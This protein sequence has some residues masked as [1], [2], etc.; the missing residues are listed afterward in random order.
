MLKYKELFAGPKLVLQLQEIMYCSR[1]EQKHSRQENMWFMDLWKPTDSVSV[2]L[3]P[4]LANCHRA[5]MQI[6]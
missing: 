1:K 4:L 5:R 2:G 6:L 3:G